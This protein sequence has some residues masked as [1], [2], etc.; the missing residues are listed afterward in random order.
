VY[1]EGG[2]NRYGFIGAC[3]TAAVENVSTIFDL[4][5]GAPLIPGTGVINV[6]LPARGI[7]FMVSTASDNGRVNSRCPNPITETSGSAV[8]APAG[9]GMAFENHTS[10]VTVVMVGAGRAW[11]VVVAALAAP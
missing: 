2:I 9:S 7:S 4:V 11:S 10:P 6:T 5:A 3:D 1:T 8:V